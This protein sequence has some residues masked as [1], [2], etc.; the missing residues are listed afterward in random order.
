MRRRHEGARRTAR[1]PIITLLSLA[2]SLHGCG[3]PS[4]TQA[5]DSGAEDAA[6]PPNDT[7]THCVGVP[8]VDLYWAARSI[9]HP[10][11]PLLAQLVDG[12]CH[13]WDLDAKLFRGTL[14]EGECARWL[15]EGK[16]VAADR[17]G[18]PV[19]LDAAADVPAPLPAGVLIE[20]TR[21]EESGRYVVFEGKRLSVLPGEDGHVVGVFS[22]RDGAV[23]MTLPRATRPDDDLAWS[24]FW[25][26]DGSFFSASGR[27]ASPDACEPTG[28]VLREVDVTT[29]T[30]T[31]LVAG[32]GEVESA[33][34]SP[35]GRMLLFATR[36]LGPCTAA[37]PT[38]ENRGV[39][40]RA[41]LWA[42]AERAL[43]WTV[44]GKLTAAAW[45]PASRAVAAAFDTTI[46]I[47]R[48]EPA[49]G[50]PPALASWPGTAPVA[51]SP[52]GSRVV[53]REGAR[54]A[55]REAR[56]WTRVAEIRVA[57]VAA[58]WNATGTLAVADASRVS[59]FRA[60]AGA[61]TESFA[62][63]GVDELSWSLAGSALYAR[64]PGGLF[65]IVEGKGSPRPLGDRSLARASCA[66]TADDELVVRAT[67]EVHR[68][69]ADAGAWS[70]TIVRVNRGE[71]VDPSGRFEA[72][73]GTILR[74][75][76]GEVL[77]YRDHPGA[78]STD[79]YLYAK[80]SPGSWVFRDGPDVL[81]GRMIR[82]K[83]AAFLR[84]TPDLGA[85]FL[86]GTALP[87]TYG[88]SAR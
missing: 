60:G 31:E 50:P 56:T 29:A 48:P 47:L 9:A 85:R 82:E 49:S 18:A 45:S 38:E 84:P 63:A 7:C 66:W 42:P 19:A 1:A 40:H 80:T 30:V 51:W 59:L 25:K 26:R 8:Q 23:V 70:D 79:S 2:L 35:D 17:T 61:P 87:H 16:G 4:S 75:A 32:D 73:P 36:S 64:T 20:G 58:A 78:L 14:P 41:H 3:R 24:A 53:S 57:A 34:P 81:G 68:F 44:D 76:D 6:A 12:T 77:H 52:D 65:V 39:L 5:R 28:L 54:L 43:R 10:T 62:L 67:L 11:R 72:G 83:D 55:I 33:L 13:V 27:G 86:A 69:K 37:P 71:R 46:Q 88:G 15:P 74:L 21:R 22:R